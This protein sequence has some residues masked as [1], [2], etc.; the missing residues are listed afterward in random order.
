MKLYK[1]NKTQYDEVVSSVLTVVV[2]IP[3]MTNFFGSVLNFVGLS[4][5]YSTYAIYLFVVLYEYYQ[6]LQVSYKKFVN[7]L[8]CQAAV[9]GVFLLN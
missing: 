5:S 2:A 1:Y 8:L 3:F 7:S 6:L 9:T 4:T